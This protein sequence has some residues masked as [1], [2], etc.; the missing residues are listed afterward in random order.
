MSAAQIE[1]IVGDITNVDVDAIV[2]AANN[3]LWMGSGVAGAIKRAG[4]EEIERDAVAKGPIDVGDAISS[5]AGRLP[6]KRV[7]H[8]AA[9]GFHGGAMIPASEDSIR[10]ATESTL[11]VAPDEGMSSLAFPALGTGIGGFSVEQ[12]AGIM[13]QAVVSFL[14]Q[15]D[16]TSV[17]RVVFVVR[18]EAAREQFQQAIAQYA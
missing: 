12:C 1:A 14:E 9:M 7:I 16:N 18:D 3:E 11:A 8:A 4:G 5:T 17:P 6:Q 10:Q 15:H 13:V 2:N